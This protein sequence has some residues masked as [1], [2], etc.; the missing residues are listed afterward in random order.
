MTRST[1]DVTTRLRAFGR[2]KNSGLAGLARLRSIEPA[3]RNAVDRPNTYTITD[4][5]GNKY[6]LTAEE[7]REALNW[8][9]PGK[10]PITKE[11]RVNSGDISVTIRADEV[12]I[13]GRGYG[14]GVGMCQWCAKGMADVGMDWRSMIE[15][16][17]PGAQITK[18]Y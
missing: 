16:F 15:Q 11:N 9:L 4:D 3:S 18:L 6:T 13:A 12:L 17:Y 10:T 1:D 14:H 2:G 5:S 8:P 7:L